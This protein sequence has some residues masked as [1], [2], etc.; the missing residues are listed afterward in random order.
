MDTLDFEWP[1]TLL[2]PLVLRQSCLSSELQ[3]SPLGNWGASLST[4]FEVLLV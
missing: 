4:K 3:C 2:V 1:P